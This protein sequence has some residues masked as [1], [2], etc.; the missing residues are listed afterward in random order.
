MT[1]S[2]PGIRIREELRASK[3]HGLIGLL[4][5]LFGRGGEMV[6]AVVVVLGCFSLFLGLL[7]LSF[8]AGT[9]LDD[10]VATGATTVSQEGPAEVV[11]EALNAFVSHVRRSA[12][13][14][15]AS[16]I[17]WSTARSGDRLKEGDALQTYSSSNAVVRVGRKTELD[18]GENSLVVL[19]GDEGAIEEPG[20]PRRSEVVLFEGELRSQVD[21]TEA[22]AFSVLA[23]EKGPKIRA[24]KGAP[25][26]MKLS[27]SKSKRSVV[28]AHQGKIEVETAN[29]PLVLGPRQFVKISETGTVSPVGVAPSAPVLVSPEDGAVFVRKKA[30]AEAFFTWTSV[31][32]DVKH[33]IEIARDD[34][35]RD[36][37]HASRTDATEFDHENL[38]PGRYYWRVSTLRGDVEGPPAAARQ[39]TVSRDARPPKLDIEEPKGPVAASTVSVDGHT[40]PG[41]S[42][43]VNGEK[44]Q[45]RNGGAFELQLT[46]Q[47]GT[48]LF[49]VEAIDE[50]GNVAYHSLYVTAKY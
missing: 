43:Y 48:N 24:S 27:V 5:T 22:G 29:G 30:K 9:G 50:A 38:K 4:L 21:A 41:C 28:V 40:E 18:I 1:K 26:A 11:S 49:V 14:K 33:R 25:S 15:P 42:V 16:T 34:K 17:A 19:R 8:P 32:T 13:T 2:K 45:T 44:V 46:L 12:K 3:E 39:F 37:V 6:A 35:F 23:G 20:A 47:P 31:E 7:T 10:L 36:V